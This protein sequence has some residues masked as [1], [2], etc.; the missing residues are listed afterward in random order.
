MLE[1]LFRELNESS[2]TFTGQIMK[3]AE[4]IGWALYF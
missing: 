2:V 1:N 3:G 4:V